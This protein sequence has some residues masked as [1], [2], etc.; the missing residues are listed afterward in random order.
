MNSKGTRRAAVGTQPKVLIDLTEEKDPVRKNT[1]GIR[2]HI[3]C[4]QCL[5]FLSAI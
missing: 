5:P 4:S 3:F 2:R 1:K